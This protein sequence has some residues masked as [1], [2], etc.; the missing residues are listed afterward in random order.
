MADRSGNDR[1]RRSG[2]PLAWLVLLIL[3]P[4]AGPAPS[5]AGPYR[6]Y[7]IRFIGE[8]SPLGK[9]PSDA[10]LI[11]A[12]AWTMSNKLDL[13]FPV[14]TKA[15][16][17]VNQATFVDGLIQIAGEERQQAWDKGRFA[18]GVATRVGL[19]LRGDHLA[20]MHLLART[21]LF[22]H[23]LTHVSQHKLAEGGRGGAAM[24]ILE[25]HADWVKFQVL[26]LLGLR[27]YRESRDEIVRSIITSKMPVKFFPDLQ[28]LAT[29]AGWVRVDES[30]RRPIH[31]W[32]GV[33]RGGLAHRALWERQG[34]RVP[35]TVRASGR[36]SRTLAHGVPDSVSPVRRRVPLT[37][38]GPALRRRGA[39]WHFS[40]KIG[41][42]PG[43][44]TRCGDTSVNSSGRGGILWTA[45]RD[46]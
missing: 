5:A 44:R 19:F 45:H 37:T 39:F 17:Y 22:A 9:S 40:P 25:G 20:R 30:A 46:E 31:V 34:A 27:Q 14:G 33:P 16:I 26:E 15:Y 2:L 23:E 18:A 38:G 24:W 43:L 8:A 4:L 42:P 35:R 28:V 36:A 41:S 10:D 32:P 7:E 1:R 29:S 12:V 3:V 11:N 6:E 13:P 21:G